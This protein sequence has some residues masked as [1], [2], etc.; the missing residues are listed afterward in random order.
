VPQPISTGLNPLLDLLLDREDPLILLRP[1]ESSLKERELAP[2]RPDF[3]RLHKLRPLPGG[4]LTEN[5]SPN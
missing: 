1:V 3:V 5:T 4:F 2:P